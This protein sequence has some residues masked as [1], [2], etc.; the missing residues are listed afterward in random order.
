[1]TLHHGIRKFIRDLRIL[2]RRLLRIFSAIWLS[3][4]GKS[5]PTFRRNV[6]P[7]S[8]RKIS[9]KK[10]ASR[11]TGCFLLTFFAYSLTLKMEAKCP[12]NST[13]LHGVI[14]Q[15]IFFTLAAARSSNIRKENVYFALLEMSFKHFK[16][17]FSCVPCLKLHSPCCGQT[18]GRPN[19]RWTPGETST[20][21]WPSSRES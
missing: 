19:R 21:G 20:A 10:T 3:V 17:P 18:D 16:L 11:F 15:K 5:L 1:M 14:S 6:L 13:G 2:R 9:P 12:Q 7:L 4:C 8:R